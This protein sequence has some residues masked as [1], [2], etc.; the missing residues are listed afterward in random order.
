MNVPS[1]TTSS[2]ASSIR[3]N[4]VITLTVPTKTYDGSSSRSSL[5]K[6]KVRRDTSSSDQ[7]IERLTALVLDHEEEAPNGVLSI[8]D[9]AT[10][11][12]DVNDW[13]WMM[14]GKKDSYMLIAK[15]LGKSGSRQGGQDELRNEEWGGEHSTSPVT[16]TPELLNRVRKNSF[17]ARSA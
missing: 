3:L 1:S 16:L 7:L 10:R 14:G 5:K 17:V 6:R 12:D 9:T 8:N 2:A 13:D 11:V 4:E 15:R